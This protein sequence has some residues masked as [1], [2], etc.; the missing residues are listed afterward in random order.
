[1]TSYKELSRQIL[2]GTELTD[3]LI[4][5]SEL[6]FDHWSSYT[7]PDTPGRKDRI[8][9]TEER[10]KF[11][12]APKIFSDE[13]KAMALHSFA[14]HELLA[15]EMMAGALLLYPHRN[16][17]EIRFKKGIVKALADEQKHFSL[18]VERINQLGFEFGDFPVNDF[19]WKQMLK[20]KT[21]ENFTA[22]MSL[23]FEAA[24]L[25]FAQYYRDLFKN[26]GDQQT[27]DILDIVLEDEI[28]HVAFGSHWLK[29]WRGDKTLWDYYLS[30][31][32][33]PLTPARGKGLH[34]DP[35]VHQRAMSEDLFVHE[36]SH[37]VDPFP[38]TRR[39]R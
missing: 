24:N 17:E 39:K 35:L 3:K 8:A 4:S 32:P 16:D 18:Y 25:D 22:V 33:H 27:A 19:F 30:V 34:Y 14:N 10:I 31:L 23:T 36:L 37:Y 12:K 6:Q 7:L 1:M 9:F 15:I 20:L 29:R 5:I 13:G 2:E 26:E 28:S 38:V 11:P 21:A